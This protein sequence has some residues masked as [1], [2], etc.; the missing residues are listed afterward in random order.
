MLEQTFS[1]DSLEFQERI[2]TR[3]GLS[4]ETYC[5]HSLHMEPPLCTLDAAREEARMVL[6][7][8][9]TEVLQK[10]GGGPSAPGVHVHVHASCA[11]AASLVSACKYNHEH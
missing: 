10:T 2:H 9:V 7:G 11:A 5:P 8:A 4:E 1:E 6:F 3:N